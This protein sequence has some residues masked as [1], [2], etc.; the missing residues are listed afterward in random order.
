MTEV[1]F[2]ILNG[3]DRGKVLTELATPVSIGREEG[4][5]IRLKDVGVS[6]FH[7][8][9]RLENEAV[10]VADLDSTNGTKLNG[11]L[12]DQT[13]PIELGDT[14]TV[15]RST[16]LYGTVTDIIELESEN[17]EAG[18]SLTSVEPVQTFDSFQV[19]LE[20]YQWVPR[21][22]DM[23]SMTSSDRDELAR[24]L[25][26]LPKVGI[27]HL[28]ALIGQGAMARVFAAWDAK[29]E[30]AVA[31]K[32]FEPRYEQVWTLIQ[33][34]QNE[35]E[36]MSSVDQPGVVKLL[37]RANQRGR[38]YIVMNL[39]MGPT[40]ATLHR[41]WRLNYRAH[42]ERQSPEDLKDYRS[43]SSSES[44]ATKV[45][46]PARQNKESTSKNM[47]LVS[48]PFRTAIPFTQG[49]FQQ[50]ARL[51]R[52]IL[53]ALS[54]SHA[55]GVLHRDIKPSNLLLDEEGKV[56]V[57]DF[58]LANVDYKKE[59]DIGQ[60]RNL[61]DRLTR[62]GDLLGTVAYLSPQ[63]VDGNYS[64]QSDLYS[65]GVTLY[66][67]AL[68]RPIWQDQT[69]N[70]IL[71]HLFGQESPSGID[72]DSELLPSELAELINHLLQAERPT[73]L[74]T[75]EE[76]R[77]C[78]DNYL[79]GRP[80]DLPENP[81]G[82]VTRLRIAIQ[83]YLSPVDIQVLLVIWAVIV[84]A[85]GL[86]LGYKQYGDYLV[87]KT[88]VE[89]LRVSVQQQ[90]DQADSSVKML[91]QFAEAADELTPARFSSFARP[92][93]DGNP[94]LVSAGIAETVPFDQ[95]NAFVQKQSDNSPSFKLSRD[96]E[97]D[98]EEPPAR[99][100]VLTHYLPSSGTRTIAG[101]DLASKEVV[102]T[103]LKQ[104]SYTDETVASE[105][106]DLGELQVAKNVI[107]FVQRVD[108][109][110]EPMLFAIVSVGFSKF[111]SRSS[112]PENTQSMFIQIVP[113]TLQDRVPVYEGDEN[114]RSF[115]VTTSKP[116]FE[117]PLRA[118]SVKWKM[119]VGLSNPW[120][121]K[122]ISWWLLTLIFGLVLPIPLV[123]VY[124]LANRWTSI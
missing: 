63:A 104:T 117:F 53:A 50:V 103:A 115:V 34:F 73:N 99:L 97:I 119:M 114:G 18:G 36:A 94:K 48:E 2:R 26:R 54:F 102:A 106:T 42:L 95:L 113:E 88:T 112:L 19:V 123:I 67:L 21:I 100:V 89:S 29:L 39:V 38:V 93:L 52:D 45:A 56:W 32:L 46:L 62:H 116:D 7:A 110:D 27:Y 71:R 12:V 69:E 72:P 43:S 41:Q 91:A 76:M 51:G 105:A 16:L 3:V 14:I 37:D 84:S 58:G 28:V 90:L 83:E 15:G 4:N 122:P 80:F 35:A 61:N 49:H 24:Q 101:F 118:G 59:Q 33:R 20:P 13:A 96:R 44:T 6:R 68:L 66:E 107:V 81:I 87:Y 111:L 31:V 70:E 124:R 25:R 1:N 108:R 98:P 74:C 120:N 30:R 121:Q 64:E 11:E 60:T 65:L 9:I 79:D 17:T 75:A 109:R 8:E 40:L 47:Q 55:R 5:T 82:L 85:F 22:R 86:I 57:V 78:F 77:A 10:V 23:E 92:I